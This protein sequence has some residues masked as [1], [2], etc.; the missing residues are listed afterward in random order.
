MTE[1]Y[2]PMDIKGG[3]DP[4]LVISQSSWAEMTPE[5]QARITYESVISMRG[6]VIELSKKVDMINNKPLSPCISMES[7]IVKLEK[8][9]VSKLII[10][11]LGSI[12]GGFGGSHI[13]K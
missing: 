6:D 7:R 9:K 1:T 2:K 12:A 3:I 10:T 5:L 13:P 8:W 4:K 11:A